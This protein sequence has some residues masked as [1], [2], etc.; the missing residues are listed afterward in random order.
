MKNKSKS[1]T[2]FMRRELSESEKLLLDK[3][4]NDEIKILNQEKKENN[5]IKIIQYK[6]NN[7][8]KEIEKK[9]DDNNFN[10]T[11]ND[12]NNKINYDNLLDDNARN[13]YRNNLYKA[14]QEIINKYIKPPSQNLIKINS[15]T[16]SINDNNNNKLNNIYNDKY[17]SSFIN[18]NF[19]NLTE[20]LLY[21]T[22]NI[23]C[24][25]KMT[26]LKNNSCKNIFCF[27]RNKEENIIN[28]ELN[29]IP[30]LL[31]NKKIINEYNNKNKNEITNLKLSNK[32]FGHN[33]SANDIKETKKINKKIKIKNIYKVPNHKNK[34]EKNLSTIN[35]KIIKPYKYFPVSYKSKKIKNKISQI[36]NE[37]NINKNKNKNHTETEINRN[38]SA[39][40][41]KGYKYKNNDFYKVFK[42]ENKKTFIKYSSI[43]T[44]LLYKNKK[45]F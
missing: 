44:E 43:I 15:I 32:G 35:N 24:P 26:N 33:L 42:P 14:S 41:I 34:I 17:Y 28:N 37:N 10:N 6:N 23:I 3:Y 2:N 8:I 5:N 27:K 13:I 16:N 45:Y 18:Y 19:I 9:Y 7:L 11:Y 38:Q 40:I 4:Q 31:E 29:E 22:Q 25:P 20:S 1:C 12:N 21:K 30:K 39:K 36:N